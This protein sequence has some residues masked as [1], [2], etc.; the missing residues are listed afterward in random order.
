MLTRRFRALLFRLGL[1]QHAIDT[2]QSSSKP[3]P[4]RLF[5]L[6]RLRHALKQSMQRVARTIEAQSRRAGFRLV[7][8]PGAEGGTR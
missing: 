2:E 6:K 4:I 7:G 5:R 3:D 1:I 8:R